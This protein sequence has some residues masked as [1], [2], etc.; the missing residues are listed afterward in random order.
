MHRKRKESIP[1]K[2]GTRRTFWPA[3]GQI[4][5]SDGMRV[6]RVHISAV[7]HSLGKYDFPGATLSTTS[8]QSNDNAVDV[9]G[10]SALRRLDLPLILP[11]EETF[12]LFLTAVH[13]LTLVCQSTFCQKM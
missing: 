7:H 4:G 1:Q 13:F 5:P 6:S 9:L 2:D 10:M 12:K 8:K 3:G 11:R